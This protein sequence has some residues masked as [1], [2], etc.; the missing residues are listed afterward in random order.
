MIA[1]YHLGIFFPFMSNLV[2]LKKGAH[3]DF[4]S[5][6]AYAMVISVLMMAVVNIV[7]LRL[8]LSWHATT[9]CGNGKLEKCKWEI[10]LWWGQ[11]GDVALNARVRL[12]RRGM[13]GGPGESMGLVGPSGLQ[14]IMRTF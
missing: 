6:L 13:Q 11:G 4:F 8:C 2:C 14:R 9:S 3:I 1:S 10:N 7:H 5:N 12:R